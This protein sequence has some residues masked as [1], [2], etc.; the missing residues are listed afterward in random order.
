M[1]PVLGDDMLLVYYIAFCF[2]VFMVGFLLPWW[3]L[4]DWWGGENTVD[5]DTV[6]VIACAS[7]VIGFWNW[8]KDLGGD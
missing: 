8:L 1:G 2:V 3:V 5:M 4:V 7:W 6:V